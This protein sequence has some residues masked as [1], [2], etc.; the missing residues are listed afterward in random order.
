MARMPQ[1]KFGSSFIYR[2]PVAQSEFHY[3]SINQRKPHFTHSLKSSNICLIEINKMF[4]ETSFR[5][6]DS[7]S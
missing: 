2:A 4:A 1:R 7:I 5:L 3:V 6:T